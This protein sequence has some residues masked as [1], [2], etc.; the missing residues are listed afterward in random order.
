MAQ[1]MGLA[2]A[3]ADCARAVLQAPL[4]EQ[5]EVWVWQPEEA[6][7]PAGYLRQEA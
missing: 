7:A 2:V 3:V 4:L 5:E 1:H 6:E